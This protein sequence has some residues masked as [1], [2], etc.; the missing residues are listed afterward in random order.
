MSKK[1]LI[2]RPNINQSVK[3]YKN[4]GV[5]VSLLTNNKTTLMI[6]NEDRKREERDRQRE[7]ESLTELSISSNLKI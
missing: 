2:L 3:R 6:Q 7:R 1:R 5:I 4:V